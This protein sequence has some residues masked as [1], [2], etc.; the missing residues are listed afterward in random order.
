[1]LK[2]SKTLQIKA[3][4]NLSGQHLM[5]ARDNELIFKKALYYLRISVPWALT[6]PDGLP[7]RTDKSKLNNILENEIKLRTPSA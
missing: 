4:R 7:A 2:L 3:E 5:L 1:M 6:T